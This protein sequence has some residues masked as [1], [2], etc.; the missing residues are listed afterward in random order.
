VAAQLTASQEGLSSM[1]LVTQ[2]ISVGDEAC[3]N[4]LNNIS[5][6]RPAEGRAGLD[7]YSRGAR[8]EPRSGH[9]P[10]WPKFIM[11]F[12]NPCRQRPR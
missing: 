1:E 8:L 3:G 6:L 5:V 10:L 12:P 4:T 9:R 7:S 11:V 2:A